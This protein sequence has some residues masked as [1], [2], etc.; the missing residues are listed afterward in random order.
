MYLWHYISN[1]SLLHSVNK[2]EKD[3]AL[4]NKTTIYQDAALQA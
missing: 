2:M 3:A 4:C 1:A